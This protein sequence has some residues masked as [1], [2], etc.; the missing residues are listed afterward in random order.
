M[1]KKDEI[2]FVG[3]FD[4]NKA[5]F[6]ID[7]EGA[8]VLKINTSADELAEVIKSIAFLRNRPIE[9][10]LKGLSRSCQNAGSKK[11]SKTIR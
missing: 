2:K 9:F 5:C 3:S 6:I 11:Q 4:T 10:T 1:T 8:A 7:G